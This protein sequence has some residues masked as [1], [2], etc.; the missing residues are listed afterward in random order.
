MTGSSAPDPFCVSYW[1]LASAH[2]SA[3]TSGPLA[4]FEREELRGSQ[5][6]HAIVDGKE[7]SAGAS[8]V[9]P[10]VGSETVVGVLDGFAVSPVSDVLTSARPAA[11]SA[12]STTI[13]SAAFARE[14]IGSHVDLGFEV[15]VLPA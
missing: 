1:R 3:D 9:G 10:V 2:W 5:A 14:S 13:T 11:V 15:D 6:S 12:T 8:K 4:P 7:S